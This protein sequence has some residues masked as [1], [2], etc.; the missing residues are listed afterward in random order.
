MED[1]TCTPP[2]GE[3]S[4]GGLVLLVE[5]EP[6]IR[7]LI[8][9]ALYR[10]GYCVVEA[11]NGREALAL[12]DRMAID[13]LIV[14][15]RL[16]YVG[17]EEVIERIQQRRPTLKILSMSG[18]PQNASTDRGVPFLAKPFTKDKLLENVRALLKDVPSN[19]AAAGS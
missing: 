11:R 18:Y 4:P 16:P 6:A 15:M 13:L 9:T 2:D 5:D 17:G 8:T 3:R 14:D 12:V 19:S 7:G 1:R 10:A